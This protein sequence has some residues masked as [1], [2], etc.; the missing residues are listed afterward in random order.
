M[1]SR[2]IEM[3]SITKQTA[4]ELMPLVLS[5]ILIDGLILVWALRDHT[6]PIFDGAS[7]LLSAFRCRDLL[8]HCH[9]RSLDWWRSVAT[10][11]VLY[12]PLV[13]L[14]YGIAKILF[15]TSG[16][17][18]LLV[19]IAF[20]NLLAISLY[21][22]SMVLFEKKSVA[23]ASSILM[24]IYPQIFWLTHFD[25]LDLPGFAFVSSAQA[26]FS[27][28]RC[29]PTYATCILAGLLSALA[30]LAK[31]NEVAFIL[32][33]FVYFFCVD[34]VTKRFERI[35]QLVCAGLVVV[36]LVTPWLIAAYPAMS[37]VINTAQQSPYK[38]GFVQNLLCYL[39]YS[40]TLPS[41]LL[42]CFFLLAV[43]FAKMSTH[44]RLV[45]LATASIIGLIVISV[46]RWTPDPRY[47]IPIVTV[48][49]LY[50]GVFLVD[51]LKFKLFLPFTIVVSLLFVQQNYVRLMPR[52]VPPLLGAAMGLYRD[53][54]PEWT[55]PC[56]PKPPGDWGY[57][58]I[59]GIIRSYSN[60]GVSRD[61]LVVPASPDVN[62]STLIYLN[63]RDSLNC[64]FINVREWSML[65]D[66]V[67]FDLERAKSFQWIIEK[68]GDQGTHIADRASENAY[69]EWLLFPISSAQFKIAGTKVLP[70]GS[71]LVVYQ[72][73]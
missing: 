35:R 11:N 52:R 71:T 31:N 50:S 60:R 54:V 73:K 20:A 41:P 57:E 47:E 9:F 44:R 18:D 16:T 21:I 2:L 55:I 72:K 7:H 26:A 8:L 49:A 40:P 29:R 10:V 14:V 32:P 63:C 27:Y 68:T 5:L 30:I 46:F 12:P 15:G 58:M 65:G 1:T 64:R 45:P 56:Y 53:L 19:R 43:I 37:K 39:I 23:C 42:W 17:V 33:M 66:K 62:A 48:M 69:N 24:L 22:H 13:Y 61:A 38:A 36:A 25:L 28:W 70:D 6:L 67:S 4:H 51:N 3:R 59:T 34:L